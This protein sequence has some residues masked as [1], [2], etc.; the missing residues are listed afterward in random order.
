MSALSWVV[1]ILVGGL[2]LGLVFGLSLFSRLDAGQRVVNGLA[3]V[4]APGRVAGDAVGVNF[5][6]DIVNLSD[7]IMTPAGGAAAEVPQLVALVSQKTG[8]STA[9]VLSTLTT[10]FPHLTSLLEAIPLSS[11]TAEL[12]AFDALLES[13]LHLNATQLATALHTNFPQLAQSISNLPTVTN[14]WNNVPGIA[15]MR[16]TNGTPVQTVPQV[17][18]R[19]AVVPTA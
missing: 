15:G 7:P 8:L 14:G 16:L 9:Q 18:V 2:V 10:K 17:R 11:V 12:P 13:T 3:P 1:V 4:N 6:S 19:I 5:I